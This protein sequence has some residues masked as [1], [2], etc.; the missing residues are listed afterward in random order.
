MFP[1]W[2]LSGDVEHFCKVVPFGEA[3]P[4]FPNKTKCGVALKTT[5]TRIAVTT[6]HGQEELLWL[7]QVSSNPAASISACDPSCAE[8]DEHHHCHHPRMV[9]ICNNHPMFQF[10]FDEDGMLLTANK[11][12]MH[13]LRGASCTAFT[14]GGEGCTPW[15]VSV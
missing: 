1:A 11:R 8:M 7:L 6:D 4:G 13:N 3:T 15:V 12:A 5:Y 10:L 2:Q 14:T 9:E